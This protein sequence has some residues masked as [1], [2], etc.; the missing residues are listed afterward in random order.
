M[1]TINIDGLPRQDFFRQ[2]PF[3]LSQAMNDTMFDVRKNTIDKTWPEAFT[4][5]NKT[6]PRILWQVER[7]QVR[8]FRSS[9]EMTAGVVQKIQRDWVAR[10]ADGGVKTNTRGGAVAIPAGARRTATG[11]I[12]KNEK[13]TPVRNR[14]RVFVINQGQK[15]LVLERSRSGDEVKLWYVMQPAVRIDKRFRFH[16]DGAAVIMRV[17]SGHFQ[18]RMG[19]LVFSGR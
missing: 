6:L 5:R 17:F 14:P 18:R 3:A 12:T 8:D 2:I 10:Q 13:P 9:G 11:R 15:R 19:A 16:E 4:V 1:I 7:A